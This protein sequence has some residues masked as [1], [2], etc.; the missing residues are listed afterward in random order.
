M[1]KH[2]LFFLLAAGTAFSL[3]A[4][5]YSQPLITQRVFDT[6]EPGKSGCVFKFYFPD[7]KMVM[8]ELTKISMLPHLP[9]LDSMIRVT[10]QILD[11]LKDSLQ[12][13]GM[14]R[15]VDVLLNNSFPNIRLLNHQEFSNTY[16]VKD[17]ELLLLK[18]NQDTLR[19][20]GYANTGYQNKIIQDGETVLSEMTAKFSVTITLDNIND[21]SKIPGNMMEQCLAVLTPQVSRFLKVDNN[22]FNWKYN[23][24]AS[25]SMRTGKMFSPANGRFIQISERGFEPVLGFSTQYSRGFFAPGF[26][27]GYQLNFGNNYFRNSFRLFMETQFLFSRDSVNR[28][29][30]DPNSF[31]TL[32]FRQFEKTKESNHLNFVANLSLSYLFKRSG[33]WYEPQTFRLGLPVFANRHFSIEPELV[34]NNF[35]KNVSPGIRFV[36]HF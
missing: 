5:N 19:I 29:K 30:T 36:L 20:I 1:K 22:F 26:F 4:Q 2:F 14:V 25:F 28:L 8:L 33:N 11:P 15:R 34:F 23:F 31:I 12:N 6:P 18:M 27:A 16:T 3:P 35:F 21:L 13:D 9:D 7:K 17:K 24:A 10:S 32:Q